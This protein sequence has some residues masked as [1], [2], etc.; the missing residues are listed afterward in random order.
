MKFKVLATL[1]V[2]PVVLIGCGGSD[3]EFAEVHKCDDYAAHPEDPGKWAEGVWEEDLVP[4]PAVKHCTEAVD[5]HPGTARFHFQLGRALWV[6][7]RVDEGL[8]AFFAAQE[9]DYAPAYAYLGDAYQEG[10]IPGE[11]ADPEFARELYAMA[12]EGGFEPAAAM[13]DGD[14][15]GGA[16]GTVARAGGGGRQT[17]GVQGGDGG[18]PPAES[19]RLPNPD[20]FKHPSW[21]VALHDGDFATLVQVEGINLYLEGIQTFMQPENY[22]MIDASCSAVADVRLSPRLAGI[23]TGISLES[24]NEDAMLNSGSFFLNMLTQYTQDPMGYARF[25]ASLSYLMA[26]GERDMSTLI[27]EFADEGGCVSPEVRRTYNNISRLL[28]YAREVPADDSGFQDMVAPPGNSR[29]D[30][31]A[32]YEASQQRRAQERQQALQASS[33]RSSSPPARSGRAPSRSKSPAT[34]GVT[35]FTGERYGGASEKF[36]ADNADLANS[37]VGEDAVSSV[38]V[39]SGCSAVLFSRTQY[40]GR[41][42]TV[43]SD[44]PTLRLDWKKRIRQIHRAG[45]NSISSIKVDCD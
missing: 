20:F 39:D 42:V 15:A 19:L 44:T 17:Q 12:V 29:I 33:S 24:S 4:G 25:Q 9:M 3:Q 13:L 23:R 37:K 21:L 41:S 40:R 45:N 14:M 28:D 18:V 36:I 7:G 30:L 6:G 2:I 16:G 35:L 34:R 10:L 11:E 38:R 31:K 5:D 43:D 8:E 26:D 32:D 27:Q 22:R 1:I